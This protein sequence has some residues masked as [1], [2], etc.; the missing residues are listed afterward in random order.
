[1]Q[2]VLVAGPGSG[3]QTPQVDGLWLQALVAGLRLLTDL[4]KEWVEQ[5]AV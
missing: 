5:L 1:M 2:S 4:M 3:V